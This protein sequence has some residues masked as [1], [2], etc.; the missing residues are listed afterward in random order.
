VRRGLDLVHTLVSSKNDWDR[1]K[2]LQWQ[3]TT[4]YVRAHPDD[5]GLPEPLELSW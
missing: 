1:Y 2:G 3:A 4:D 5:P